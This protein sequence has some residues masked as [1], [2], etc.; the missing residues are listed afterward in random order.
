MVVCFGMTNFKTENFL[1]SLL[2][3]CKMLDYVVLY[4]EHI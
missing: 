2:K 3:L 4:Q 1:V